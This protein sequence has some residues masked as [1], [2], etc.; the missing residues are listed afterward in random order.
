MIKAIAKVIVKKDH[1]AYLSWYRHRFGLFPAIRAY[2]ELRR[3][4]IASAPNQLTGCDVFLRP[5]TTDQDVYDEIFISREYDIDL[6]EPQFIVDAGAHIGLSS[7]FFASR[8]PKATIIALEPEPSNFEILLMN[9]RNYPNI[10]PLQA[11]L[12][13][14]K[15][16]LCIE[17]SNV[18]TW[19]FRVVE[20]STDS[21]ISAIGIQDMLLNFKTNRIDVLKIDIEGSECEVL[22]NCASWI[23]KVGTIV[24]ELHD[25]FR[26]GCTEALDAAISG[27]TYQKFISGES[28]VISNLI[29]KPT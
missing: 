5:G 17:N 12:W 25:R 14:R 3:R 6:G 13:S 18:P 16:Q 19:S 4:G 27:H 28:I 2:I 9:T 24:I 1:W 20:S 23:D 22:N 11:G 29:R 8:Y 21:G 10:K 26:P 7:M 15:T